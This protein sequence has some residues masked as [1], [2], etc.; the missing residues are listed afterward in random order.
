MTSQER[1]KAFFEKGPSDSLPCIEWAHWWGLTLDRWETEG[2]DKKLSP[3]ELKKSFELDFDHQIWFRNGL[4]GNIPKVK[5]HGYISNEADYDKILPFLY[6]KQDIINMKRQFEEIHKNYEQNGDIFWFTL[7][8]FFWFPRELFGIEDHL[9]SF[10]DCP[11]LYHRI[12]RD[13]TEYYLFIIDEM[14]KYTTP[15]FMTFAEDMSYNLG[16]MLSK[17]TFS[18][19]IEPYYKKIIPAL[20]Q[21][22][23]KVIVDSDGDIA[24]MIPWFIESGVEGI[25]PLERQA[26]VD[27]DKLTVEYPDFFFIGGFDKMVMKH[28]EEAMQR[29]FERIYPAMRRKNYLPSVDHQTPPDVSL[30]NYHIYLNLLKKYC[31]KAMN[32]DSVFGNDT[33]N[34]K[35]QPLTDCSAKSE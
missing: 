16:P 3:K 26:G 11:E 22:G 35:G 13:M 18:E 34:N 4:G 1:M 29:E 9:Y 33:G 19:F 32:Y 7:S 21:K 23:I 5:E 30:E 2:L 17:D 6:N 24:K 15:L 27:V 28:G 10:Y 31:L 8:G 14:T 12:C 25:L 20:K